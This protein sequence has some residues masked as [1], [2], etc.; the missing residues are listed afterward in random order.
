MAHKKYQIYCDMDGVL[1][2]Y[3]W[4]ASKALYEKFGLTGEII[5]DHDF[6]G[7]VS[8]LSKVYGMSSEFNANIAK[9]YSVKDRYLM[10]FIKIIPNAMR[11][12]LGDDQE[13]WANLPWQSGGSQLWQFI[14]EFDPIILSSPMYEGSKLG[15][16]E[17]VNKNLGE[18][19][20][21]ILKSDKSTYANPNSILIDD[22]TKHLNPWVEAGGIAVHHKI[23]KDTISHLK[24]LLNLR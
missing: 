12:M 9:T 20:Q 16:Q 14:K 5:T 1:C 13:F 11:Y 3:N 17:W 6:Y 7:F 18:N 4:A 21:I 2:N 24:S 19:V 22:F 23:P 10:T 15:K 8:D